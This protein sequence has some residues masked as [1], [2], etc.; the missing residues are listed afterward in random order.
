MTSWRFSGV[1]ML[2]LRNL[3][4]QWA[5][6]YFFL[7]LHV[8]LSGLHIRTLKSISSRLVKAQSKIFVTLIFSW[9]RLRYTATNKIYS[10]LVTSK[11][12]YFCEPLPPG[13]SGKAPEKIHQIVQK[14][15]IWWAVS[16]LKIWFF[17]RA[18]PKLPGGKRLTKIKAF[19]RN[20][21]W[22]NFIGCCIT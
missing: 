14:T 17:P 3:T 4:V 1:K 7:P 11:K 2:S 6:L 22:I 8:H 16:H 21:T 10:C 15:F 12:A 19:R 13:G 5:S 20:K 18:F 9:C